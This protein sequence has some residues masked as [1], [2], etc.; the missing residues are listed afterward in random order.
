LLDYRMDDYRY[1]QKL[2]N[3]TEKFHG[4]PQSPKMI[5]SNLGRLE[6]M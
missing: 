4:N 2:D 6:R 5:G 3:H 1:L